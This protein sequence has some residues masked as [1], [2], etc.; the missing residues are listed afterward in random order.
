MAELEKVIERLKEIAEY[1][2]GCR[3]NASFASKAENHFW[4]LQ[5]AASEAV[6][7]LKAQEPR[8]MTLDE[9]IKH[10]SLPPVV[11][12]DLEWQEDYLQDIEPLYFDFPVEDSFAVHWRG[13]QEVW[14]YLEDWK[15]SYGQK[16]RCWTSR[17]TDEQMKAVKWE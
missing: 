5:N 15:A 14:K 1:F 9:V 16:W 6:S 7:L 11:L 3:N 4:E 8:V 10:Y 2:R 17:P 13:Y 12:D